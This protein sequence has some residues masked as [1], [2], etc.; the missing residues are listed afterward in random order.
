[1]YDYKDACK[2][3]RF[4]VVSTRAYH[5][6]NARTRAAFANYRINNITGSTAEIDM[7]GT[8][9][10]VSQVFTGMGLANRFIAITN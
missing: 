10:R 7:T 9:A 2:V 6:F 3:M 4:Y 1:M 5:P 8:G